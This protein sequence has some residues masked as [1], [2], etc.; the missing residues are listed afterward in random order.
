MQ[1]L[2]LEQA[3]EALLSKE[4]GLKLQGHISKSSTKKHTEALLS[5]VRAEINSQI[6]CDSTALKG[7][8]SV[9][10]IGIWRLRQLRYGAR[11]VAAE[12]TMLVPHRCRILC[13][14]KGYPLF[15]APFLGT[16]GSRLLKA[17]SPHQCCSTSLTLI[18]LTSHVIRQVQTAP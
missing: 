5:R 9:E 13:S 8:E 11:M 1:K 6:M 16:R 3:Q 4:V 15:F 10:E 14:S 2:A 7:N 18:Q 17:S 12:A